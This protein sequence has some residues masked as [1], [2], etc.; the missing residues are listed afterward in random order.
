MFFAKWI[1]AAGPEKQGGLN[2]NI[3]CDQDSDRCNGESASKVFSWSLC[4][5]WQTEVYLR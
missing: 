3:Y 4:F 5:S 2:E 1:D